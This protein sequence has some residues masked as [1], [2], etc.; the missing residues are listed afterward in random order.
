MSSDRRSTILIVDDNPDN[1]R[2]LSDLLLESDCELSIATDGEMALEQAGYVDPDLILLDVLM[3]EMD[4]FETCNRLKTDPATQDIPIIFMTALGDTVDK[5]RGFALG[6]VDYIAKPAQAEEVLARINVHLALRRTARLLQ[7]ENALLRQQNT[8]LRQAIQPQ[9]QP[10]LN[11]SE[12]P[13]RHTLLIVDDNPENL[14]VLSALL[15]DSGCDILVATDGEMALEQAKYV[16]PE[17]ILLDVLMPEMDGFEVCQRLRSD[18]STAEIPVIFM[19]ALT[20]TLDKVRGFSLGAVDYITKPFQAEEVLARIRVHL[21]LFDLAHALEIQ[22]EQLK[23]K[24]EQLQREIHDRQSVETELEKARERAETANRA[25]SEFLATVS[26]EIRTPM[27]AVIG[28]STLLLD[29]PL[30]PEQR[31]FVQ[32]IRNGGESLLTVINDVLD[33]SRI[34]SGWLE[35]EQR[36]FN[37]RACIEDVLNLLTSHA[38]EKHLELTGIVD[39]QVPDRILGDSNRLRQILINLISNAIKFT[40]SGTV[41]LVVEVVEGEGRA[42]APQSPSQTPLHLLVPCQHNQEL[43][44]IVGFNALAEALDTY[45]EAAQERVQ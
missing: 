45:Q 21:R 28:M 22:N 14:R 4:G 26:H 13:R 25:K 12:T 6:A 36:P 32:T 5:L 41:T 39:R 19:T 23:Q 40:N 16:H 35:L 42:D 2:V 1:L 11:P 24:N 10:T 3:P 33:F 15:A 7:A 8:T 29:T 17:L 18:P 38:A 34:E 37:L 9:T 43:A 44:K 30:T 20:D 27:N 31:Q